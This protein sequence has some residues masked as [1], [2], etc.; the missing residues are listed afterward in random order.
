MTIKTVPI[1]RPI[2]G[3]CKYQVSVGNGGNKES[4]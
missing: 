4:K 2:H 3:T 1:R